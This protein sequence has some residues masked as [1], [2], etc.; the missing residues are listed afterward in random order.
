M[1][2]SEGV[3][4]ALHCCAVLALLPPQATLPSP[5]LAEMHGLPRPYLAKHLQALSAAGVVQSVAGARGGYRLARPA[6]DLTLLDVVQAVEGDGHAFRCTEIR[7]QGP[8]PMPA[9][10]ANRACGIARAMWAAEGAW[11]QEL[12]STSLADLATD[13]ATSIEP[14]TARAA[15]VWIRDRIR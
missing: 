7:Q 9:D 12:R 2:M 11:R 6:A 15:A 3:E 14:D 8:V 13:L 5:V 4:W 1:Q 10:A